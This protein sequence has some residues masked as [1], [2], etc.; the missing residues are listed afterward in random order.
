MHG[1]S[2][3]W[4]AVLAS[5]V[6]A[7]GLTAYLVGGGDEPPPAQQSFRSLSQGAL[8][9]RLGHAAT[10]HREAALTQQTAASATRRSALWLRAL[11]GSRLAPGRLDGTLEV[12]PAGAAARGR[13]DAF[14]T[15]A[16]DLP[17]SVWKVTM[18]LA[19]LGADRR[20]DVVTVTAFV[21]V[22]VRQA[23]DGTRRQRV[24]VTLRLVPVGATAERAPTSWR[25]RTIVVHGERE[26]VRGYDDPVI[27]RRD[28]IDVVAP[29]ALS[30]SAVLVADH[31]RAMLPYLRT[32]Y[33]GVATSKAATLWMLPSA[34]A[35][36]QVLGR[37]DPAVGTRAPGAE[38]LGWVDERG[39]LALDWAR[40]GGVTAEQQLALVRH[41]LTHVVMIGSIGTAPVVLLEGVA[42]LEEVDH[43]SAGGRLYADLELLDRAFADGVVDLPRLLRAAPGAE[44]APGADATGVRAAYLAGYATVRWLEDTRGH[45]RVVALLE[46]L[47]DDVPVERALR[48]VVRLDV[49]AVD[50]AVRS[51]TSTTV[52]ARAG[53]P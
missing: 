50:A 14:R 47:A 7:A 8:G 34:A 51:W 5:F 18:R 10:F 52:A 38:A 9:V 26:W 35:A 29:R 22:R 48:N 11:P 46:Q 12:A 3:T 45:G 25:L 2:H 27:V 6:A 19:E 21:D 42:T 49:A 39:E 23:R 31:A 36:K 44:F 15:W 32:R 30:D 53:T 28:G 20:T 13:L 37:D 43:H 40:M 16:D 1:Q 41:E 33:A 24:P 17:A 4:L